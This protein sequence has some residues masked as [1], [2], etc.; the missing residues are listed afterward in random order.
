MTQTGQLTG[1]EGNIVTIDPK[2]DAHIM[3]TQVNLKQGL[4]K[5]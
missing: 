5:Y 2:T 1:V 3:I 4:I